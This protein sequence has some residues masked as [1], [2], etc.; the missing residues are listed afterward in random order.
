[1]LILNEIERSVRALSATPHKGTFRDEIAPDLRAIQAGRRAV[2]A[3][4]VHDKTRE[5]RV[6]A[7]TYGGTDWLGPI[8]S[9]S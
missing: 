9:R 3:F 6:V 1:L 7:I 5:V 2:V 4:I 8:E